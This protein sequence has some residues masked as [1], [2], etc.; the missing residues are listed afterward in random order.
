[1]SEKINLVLTREEARVLIMSLCAQRLKIV[2][3]HNHI[4]F[5]NSKLCNL[6]ERLIKQ[7]V[8]DSDGV[9]SSHFS[10]EDALFAFATQTV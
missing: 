2:Y 4:A 8:F 10:F 6:E 7:V 3:T 9:F 1:M 5:L